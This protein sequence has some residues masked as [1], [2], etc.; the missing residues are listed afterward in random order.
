MESDMKLVLSGLVLVLGVLTQTSFASTSEHEHPMGP[1][2]CSEMEAW[3]FASGMCMP[4][5]MKDMPMK[6][7][8]LHYNSFFVQTVEEGRRGRN[9]FSVPNMFML[10]AGSSIGDRHYLNV[11]LMGTFE[12]W[13]FPEN[14][15]PELL[16]IGE[17]NAN[18]VPY[19]DAQHPHSS[20]I[21]G[22]TLSD[23]ITL[24][25][26]KDHLKIFFAPR[27]QS[28]DGPVA[29]M[30]RPT[31]AV[32]PDAPLGHHVG[33]DVGHI[34]STVVGGVL[35]LSDTTLEVS[36]FNG[37]EPEPAKVDLP[38]ESPNSYA[39]R[40]TQMFGPHVYAM[41]S[42]AY[43]KTPEPHDPELD[44]LW[45][46]SASLYNDHIFES[47]WRI[48]NAFIWG[49]IN[50]YDEASALNSFA[51]EFWLHKNRNHIWSRIEALQRTAGQ[52]EI[53]SLTPANKP[54]WVTAL[55]IGYTRKIATW[56][57]ADVGV[58]ASL[59]KDFL[60]SEFQ[61]AYSGEPISGKIFIQVGGMKM[62][63]L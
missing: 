2:D 49:L 61:K 63:D 52:L 8:M 41:A 46:Y 35:R 26:G 39:A 25:S 60:P 14:G 1:S 9:S 32:N 15:T 27:G 51:E 33:Q 6:M 17:E 11:D 43:L 48:H 55:T 3:D 30:H 24:G 62:W 28:T 13:T 57:L 54:Q 44:H 19:L 4:L 20:P 38:L 31:G 22:L 18:H 50:D 42:A 21:M 36:T 45:R 58:G 53:S 10:D 34:S 7:F 16:Q 12:R 56:D 59:T 37:T 40:L 47:G 5:A 29:F 23:A